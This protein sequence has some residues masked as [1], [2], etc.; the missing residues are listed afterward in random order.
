EKGDVDQALS[1]LRSA[2]EGDA[3]LMPLIIHCVKNK[4]SLGE[5]S[6]T[7]RNVFGDYT[8]A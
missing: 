5:I 1:Q 3:N 2:A 7:L 6:Y 4:C 8:P